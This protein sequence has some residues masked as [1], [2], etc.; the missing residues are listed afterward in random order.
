MRKDDRLDLG[1]VLVHKQ[2]LAEIVHATLCE[3]DGV[4]PI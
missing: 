3:I 1:S 4:S 2:A